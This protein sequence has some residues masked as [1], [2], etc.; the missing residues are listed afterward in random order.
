MQAA[1]HLFQPRR[2]IDGRADTGEIEPVAAADIA[3]ENLS[4]MQSYTEAEPLDDL[5]D[6]KLHGP[7]IGARLA[8]RFKHLRAGISDIA[9]IL[10]ERKHRE[11]SVAHEFQNLAAMGS[12]RRNLA[13]EVL[14]ENF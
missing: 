13:V 2:K 8:G 6:R 5:A 1:R 14:I 3:V 12:D 9:D 10:I 4:D 7:D 11:Q